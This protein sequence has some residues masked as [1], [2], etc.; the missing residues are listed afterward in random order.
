MI[1]FIFVSRYVPVPD[2]GVHPDVM[3]FSMQGCV[4]FT[5]KVT[6]VNK[7]EKNLEKKKKIDFLFLFLFVLNV[8]LKHLIKQNC[9]TIFEKKSSKSTFNYVKIDFCSEDF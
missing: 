4:I 2:L 3:G 8:C 5:S 7:E 6:N 1:A 9:E